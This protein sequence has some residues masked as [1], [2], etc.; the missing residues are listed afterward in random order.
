MSRKI[1]GLVLILICAL[2]LTSGCAPGRAVYSKGEPVEFRIDQ[3]VI[4][5]SEGFPDPLPYMILDGEGNQLRLRHFCDPMTG[6]GFDQY[7]VNGTVQNESVIYC[8]ESFWGAEVELHQTYSW[9]QKAYNF[10]IEE[11]NGMNIYRDVPQQVPSG[12]YSV[13]VWSDAA[14]QS[15]IKEF[16][17]E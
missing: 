12:E 9:D 7:C 5:F 3:K 2:A 6:E 13:V 16:V 15:T 17:I 11:C 1:S 4:V 8:N 10:I 14:N